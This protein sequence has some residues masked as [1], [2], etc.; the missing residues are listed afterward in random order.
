MPRALTDEQRDF[1]DAIGEFCR[2][3]CGTKQQRDAL[4]DHGRHPHSREL[5]ARMA[6]LG[7]LG[8]SIPQDYGGAGRGMAE[9]CLFLEETAYGR[10]PISGFAT[11]IISAAAYEKFGSEPQKREVLSGVVRGRVEAI[12]MSEP[13]AGSDVGALRC[14]AERRPGGWVVNGQKTW[15][16]NAHIADHVLLV[17]RTSG[18]GTKHEGLTQFMV[19]TGAE[20]LRISGIDT[21]GGREVNDLYFTDCF[22]PDD[23]VVGTVGAGWSQLVSGLNLERMILAALMLGTARRAF[24]DTVSYITQREQFGRPVGTFQALRHRIADMATELECARLLVDDVAR[25]ID[26]NP[27]VLFP[28]EA[29]MAKL[30]CTE[31]AKHVALEGMQM[32]G[33]YGYATD[34][35]MESLLRSTVVSTVYGGTSE[36][37]RDIIGK[38]YGL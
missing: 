4:T 3:E 20:G 9:L 27:G 22:L 37:Q 8:V 1:V 5:Y 13:G 18:E 21:M 36:I 33:G 10:A 31:L 12:S 34:Y 17:A 35:G 16:S 14:R 24:D 23:A 32:M 6:E 29:S 2:R 15:C 7:W 38:S 26:A 19:P 11:T 30:K 28:R 25:T